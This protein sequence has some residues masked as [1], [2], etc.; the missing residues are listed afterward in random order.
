MRKWN[1]RLRTT[2]RTRSNENTKNKAIGRSG[3]GKEEA[4]KKEEHHDRRAKPQRRR[5]RNSPRGEEKIEQKSVKN[6]VVADPNEW[7]LH[8]GDRA[9]TMTRWAGPALTHGNR[10]RN[11]KAVFFM[12]GL[13][14]RLVLQA[15]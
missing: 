14:A 8:P 7:K 4:R 2:L 5:W 6:W 11:F 1:A 10:A 3:K 13:P 9:A 15:E 12:L